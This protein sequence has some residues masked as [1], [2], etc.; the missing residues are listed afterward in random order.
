MQSVASDARSPG[1]VRPA[2]HPATWAAAV[3]L[4]AVLTGCVPGGTTVATRAAPDTLPAQPPTQPPTQPPQLTSAQISRSLGEIAG[5]GDTLLASG[6]RLF[7]GSREVYIPQTCMGGACSGSDY[8][9]D[10]SRMEFVDL[11][12]TQV[13]S[14]N[15]VTGFDAGPDQPFQH[16]E[17][18][19]A[20]R[21]W[22][23]AGSRHVLR[24][25]GGFL[26]RRPRGATSQIGS[27]GVRTRRRLPC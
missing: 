13:P 2:F 22:R 11:N 23:V 5:A 26:E 19:D 17:P 10:I 15:G 27:A 4:A 6:I 8:V 9:S 20:P 3:F 25:G 1:I 21:I 24:S 16:L 18:G 12:Y 14:T 7:D